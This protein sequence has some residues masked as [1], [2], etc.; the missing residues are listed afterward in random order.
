MPDRQGSVLFLPFKEELERRDWESYCD[1]RVYHAH[2]K[3]PS[4]LDAPHHQELPLSSSS[5][6][7]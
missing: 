3:D 4:V 5:L 2:Q 1:I 6:K 7:T